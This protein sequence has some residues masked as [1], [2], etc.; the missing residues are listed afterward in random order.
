MFQI[1]NG[2]AEH[3]QRPGYLYEINNPN[4]QQPVSAFAGQQHQPPMP[5]QGY[6]GYPQ[7]QA[8]PPSWGPPQGGYQQPQQ[9][10][11]QQ[12][13][14]YPQQY[15]GGGMPLPDFAPM[16]TQSWVTE[17]EAEEREARGWGPRE[18][19][20]IWLDFEKCERPGQVSDM[21]LRLLPDFF[22]QVDPQTGQRKAGEPAFVSAR[23]RIFTE[24]V[25]VAEGGQASQKKVR[26]FNCYEAPD[27]PKDCPICRA[28]QIVKDSG[29]QEAAKHVANFKV[30]VTNCWQAILLDDPS[31][32]WVQVVDERGQPVLDGAG[33]PT[34]KQVPGVIRVKKT[35][36]DSIREQTRVK[37]DPTH[38][39]FGFPFRL[40][41]KRTGTNQMDV[42][43]TAVALDKCPIDPQ[44]YGIL[45]AAID[46]RKELGQ[47]SERDFMDKVATNIVSRWG[48][49]MHSGRAPA[50]RGGHAP[51]PGGW[52]PHTTPGASYNPTTG[53]VRPPAAFVPP[54][55][56]PGPPPSQYGAPPPQQHGY[57][58]PGG[59]YPA[60]AQQ[61]PQQSWGAP[62]G[63]PPGPPSQQQWGPPQQPQQP[64]GPPA[65]YA[66][67]QQAAP[68]QWQQP[69][70]PPPAQQQLGFG[71]PP[72]HQPPGPPPSQYGPP[73][74]P[75]SAYQ[76]PQ[77]APQQQYQPPQY[78]GQLPP[79]GAP[80]LSAGA[81]MGPPPGMA[82]GPPMGPPPNPGMPPG[83]YPQPGGPPGGPPSMGGPP[84]GGGL[85]PEQLEAQLSGKP[86]GT[87][88]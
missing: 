6:G 46:L 45:H 79:P 48:L 54:G 24:Y 55:A 43:Y 70:G 44:L 5:Q 82:G 85:T 1:P 8:Q 57:A 23:H 35:L 7:P 77:P 32:H 71:G 34:W 28:I 17:N 52:A 87:P 53:A 27:G 9:P 63:A 60:P 21:T 81:P 47:M 42:E 10:A 33:Q 62:P 61:P 78:Q 66:P 83:A 13:G 37:G 39:Q 67:P 19:N 68:Q 36:H 29:I 65:Q 11:Y 74:G 73:P 26:Y 59:G 80:G 49:S 58:P 15:G 14:G 25:P 75:P 86:G 76:Q 16:D 12:P 22:P 69:A 20:M 84:G 72:Q 50:P 40:T 88:F 56:P 30:E 18:Q 31:K 64:P 38:P 41:K 4:N 3:P 51:G 2:W